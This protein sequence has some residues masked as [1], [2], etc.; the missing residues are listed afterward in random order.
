MN[1]PVMCLGRKIQKSDHFHRKYQMKSRSVDTKP[2]DL[3][4]I[5][6]VLLEMTNNFLYKYESKTVF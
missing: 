2:I 4:R 1:L 3:S 5:D 6:C